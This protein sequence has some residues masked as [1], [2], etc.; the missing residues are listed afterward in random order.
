MHRFTVAMS[1]ECLRICVLIRSGYENVVTKG[2]KEAMVMV[3]LRM[4]SIRL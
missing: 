3:N 4:M 1:I 2:S